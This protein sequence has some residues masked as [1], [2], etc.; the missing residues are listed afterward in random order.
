MLK[1]PM[2]EQ[3]PER[4][5][6]PWRGAHVV[7]VFLAG[8]VAHRGPMLEQSVPGGFHPVEKTYNGAVHEELQPMEKT[9]CWR[10]Y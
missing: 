6:S 2:L 9:P 10:S 1:E 5:C 3:A 8:L 7:A 4:S